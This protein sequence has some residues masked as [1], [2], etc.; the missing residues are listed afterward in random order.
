MKKRASSF[1]KNAAKKSVI[2]KKE[3]KQTNKNINRKTPL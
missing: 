2:K 3:N 1:D